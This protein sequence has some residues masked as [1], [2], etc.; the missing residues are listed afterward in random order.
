N[1]ANSLASFF[2]TSENASLIQSTSSDAEVRS[3]LQRE[4]NSAIQNSYKILNTRIDKFGVTSPNIQI[5]QGTNR[6]LI[7]LPGVSDEERVRNLLQGSAQL[8]FYETHDNMEVYPLLENIDQTLASSLKTDK[9]EI[10]EEA[11]D[12]EGSDSTAVESD[13]D[14]DDLLASLSGDSARSDSSE[15]TQAELA[16]NNPL[17]SVLIP[18]TS[19]GQSGQMELMPG[20]IV[21]YSLLTDTAKVNSYLN[22]SAIKSIIPQ[23]MKLLWAVKPERQAKDLLALYAIRTTGSEGEAVLS[24]DVISDARDNFNQH[25]QPVVSMEMN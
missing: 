20:P 17:F 14:E 24:G 9:K 4:A 3:F 10:D 18:S 22:E 8:E 25:N 11:T 1:A 5:Q 16:E 15:I 23:N 21:G 12:T 7:E 6:I 19:Q 2:A 13:E